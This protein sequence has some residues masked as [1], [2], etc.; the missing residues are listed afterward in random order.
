MPRQVLEQGTVFS[1]SEVP[2]IDQKLRS[3]NTAILADTLHFESKL[4]LLYPRPLKN[5]RLATQM[6]F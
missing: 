6:N 4:T 3:Q 2:T 5:D 1:D